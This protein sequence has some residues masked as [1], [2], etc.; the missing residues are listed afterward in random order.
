MK[1][2]TNYGKII[3]VT[4]SVITCA[5][6]IAFVLYRLFRNLITFCNT[7]QLNEEDDLELDLDQL[8]EELFD[9]EEPEEEIVVEAPEEPAAE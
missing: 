8:D 1:N 4:L 7:Y 3:A 5:G 2:E 6:A 9:G